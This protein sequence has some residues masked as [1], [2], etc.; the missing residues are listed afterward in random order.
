M[1]RIKPVFTNVIVSALV[2]FSAHVES[3]WALVLLIIGNDEQISIMEISQW[4]IVFVASVMAI[5]V[6]QHMRS[7]YRKLEIDLAI[8]KFM[9]FEKF[10]DRKFT[11]ERQRF[12]REYHR[13]TSTNGN[14]EISFDE[15]EDALRR[16]FGDAYDG[17][18]PVN[19]PD[20]D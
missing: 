14:Q 13:L 9:E 20:R 11:K 4:I 10:T 15:L 3:T 6:Y 7:K 12:I 8:I 17:N 5:A 18:L 1:K 2:A 16:L 19:E